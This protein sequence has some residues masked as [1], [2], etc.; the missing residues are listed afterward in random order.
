MYVPCYR[1]AV[2]KGMLIFERNNVFCHL[3]KFVLGENMQKMIQGGMIWLFGA[4]YK[5]AS[6]FCEKMKTSTRKSI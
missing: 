5:K 1:F 6:Y 2:E 3:R 4:Y